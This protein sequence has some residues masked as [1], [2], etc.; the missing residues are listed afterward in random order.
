MKSFKSFTIYPTC[1]S[2]AISAI[3]EIVPSKRRHNK[4]MRPMR[5]GELDLRAEASIL[6]QALLEGRGDD[7]VHA[8]LGKAVEVKALH[9]NQAELRRPRG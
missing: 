7:K 6:L 8:L 2:N 5:P 3:N 9:R 4:A 1:H